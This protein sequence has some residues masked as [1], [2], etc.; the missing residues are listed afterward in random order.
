MTAGGGRQ[1][2]IVEPSAVSGP[3][4]S[5]RR[6]SWCRLPPAA[7]AGVDADDADSA[8]GPR[9]EVPPAAL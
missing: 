1:A 3:L 5:H 7:A 4:P 8:G 9:M 6:C 2:E